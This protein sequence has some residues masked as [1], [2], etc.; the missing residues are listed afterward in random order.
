MLPVLVSMGEQPLLPESLHLE[1][2][3][4][5]FRPTLCRLYNLAEDIGESKNVAADHPDVV[6]K[7]QALVEQAKD[8]LGVTGTGPGV[9]EFG[10]VEN[11]QPLISAEGVIR[12]GF[13]PRRRLR[14]DQSTRS[15]N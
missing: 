7:L 6:A 8:D 11:P 4:E 3:V 10:H 2:M 15:M 13:K 5:D 9:R 12:D 14:S 1:V